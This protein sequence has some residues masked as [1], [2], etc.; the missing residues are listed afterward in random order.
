MTLIQI[1]GLSGT[2]KST[3]C[4]ELLRRGLRA[5][6]ADAAFAYFG[7]PETGAPCQEAKRDNWIWDLRRIRQVWERSVSGVIF[8]CGGA[9]NAERCADLFSLRFLLRVD[10]ETMRHRLLTRRGNDYGK[11]PAELEE[12]LALNRAARC[13]VDV[14]GWIVVDAA[15]PLGAVVDAILGVSMR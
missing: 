2:G 6:D 15:R 13:G 4:Q 9:M 12:Q 3:I 7:D 11:D 1:D 8:V 10:D 14:P 5:V